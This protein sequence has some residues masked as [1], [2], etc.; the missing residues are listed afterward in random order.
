MWSSLEATLNILPCPS[1]FQSVSVLSL[2]F[3]QNC[4]VVENSN[5]RRDFGKSNNL[6]IVSVVFDMFAVQPV[7]S[8]NHVWLRNV[9]K[10]TSLCLN[11]FL[12]I[13]I[14]YRAMHFSAKCGIAIACRLSVRPSVCL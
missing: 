3:I 8:Q 9:N 11:K 12:L 14:F 4:K 2:Q 13:I 7:H 1:V 10:M 6:N 5:L